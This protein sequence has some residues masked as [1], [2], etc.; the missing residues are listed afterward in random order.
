M[1][2]KAFLFAT[3]HRNF[4]RTEESVRRSLPQLTFLRSADLFNRLDYCATLL[5]NLSATSRQTT[6]LAR[7]YDYALTKEAQQA[8]ESVFGEL[9]MTIDGVARCVVPWNDLAITTWVDTEKYLNKVW[10]AIS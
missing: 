6:E 8:Y 3:Q 4:S 7:Q 10:K 1:F 9:N 2:F 5:R